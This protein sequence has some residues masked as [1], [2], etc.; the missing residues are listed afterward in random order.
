VNRKDVAGRNVFQGGFLGLDNIGVFDRSAQLPTGGY[1]SQADGTAWMG[2]YAVN[3]LAIAV[4][5]AAHDKNYEHLAN[6]FFQH[7]L[8]IADAINAE[9]AGDKGLWHEQDQF[10]Y[11][12]LYLPSGESVPL[13]VRSAVGMVPIYATAVMNIDVLEHLPQL[14]ARVSW[15]VENRPELAANVAKMDSGGMSHRR[16]MAFVSPDRLRMLL[17]RFFSEDEFLSP[18]GLRMLSKAHQT[19]PFVLNVGGAS[20]RV[21]YEPAESTSGSFGGNSNWRGP[22]WFPLNYLF[23]ESLQKFHHFLG[24]DYTIEFPTGSGHYLTLWDISQELSQRLISVFRTDE[25]GKRPFQA[26][27]I[28]QSEHWREH[29]LFHEYFHGDTGKGL[30]A[31]HQTG[32]TAL[33]A[34]LI[35]QTSKYKTDNVTGR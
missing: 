15:F 6:K 31:S 16:L 14:R 12:Q 1:L 5:L 17:R 23:I 21:D 4:E 11:D 34:K 33:V 29:I 22:V 28:E 18:H 30:G 27:A 13:R 8:Y 7:F 19:D 25:N 24:D 10:Y 3:M 20:F 32:W 2:M 35:Q 9:R 26:S